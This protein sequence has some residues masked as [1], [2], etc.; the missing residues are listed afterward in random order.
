MSIITKKSALNLAI[1]SG[2][3][4]NGVISALVF[5]VSGGVVSTNIL[6]QNDSAVITHGSSA[7]GA[8]ND[9]T[10]M[11][12]VSGQIDNKSQSGWKLIV[13]SSNIGKLVRGSGGTTGTT[14][15][16]TRLSLGESAVG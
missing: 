13:A 8:A 11:I 12:A 2:L 10:G 16:A 1:F 4:L 9:Q 5:T 7:A 14:Y 3:T 6:I 15:F